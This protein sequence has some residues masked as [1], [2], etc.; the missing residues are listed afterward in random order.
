MKFREETV[1]GKKKVIIVR[2]FVENEEAVKA[3]VKCIMGPGWEYRDDT[4]SY[5]ELLKKR[6]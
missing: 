2:E 5:A 1:F 4:P 6:W 3:A